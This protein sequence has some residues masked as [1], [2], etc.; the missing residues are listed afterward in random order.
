[1]AMTEDEVRA[2]Y[3]S[4]DQAYSSGDYH[5]AG[6]LFSQLLIEPNALA[7]S[8]EIHWNYAMCLVHEGNWPLA[9][10]HVQAG[11]YDVAQFREACAQANLRDAQHDFEQASQLYQSQQWDAAAN[12]F[13]ELLVHP[14]VPAE[15][16]RELH[17]NIA[18]CLAHTGD[19]H[20]AIEH[21]RAG[22]YS[23]TD[24][25]EALGRS[26]SDLAV[27][28]LD[29]A[30]ELYNQGQWSQAA[31]AFAELLISPAVSADSMD[32]L[33]W[34]LAMC[35]AHLGNWDTAFGHIR[36]SGGDEQAFRQRAIDSGLEPPAE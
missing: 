16:M 3:E 31:E 28:Q 14:S 33:Q 9:I 6:E 18:M 22:G 17:W 20:T 4:A 7:G 32:E 27:R 21:V 5:R 8:N 34:N 23:E 35:F 15:S 36:A 25:N 26:N 24:F 12:A 19:Y 13:V 10:E 29:A 11:G 2:L 1:M 30:V